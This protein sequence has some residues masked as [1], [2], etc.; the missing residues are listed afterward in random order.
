[1]SRTIVKFENVSPKK[2]MK[3]LFYKHNEVYIFR[4]KLKKFKGWSHWAE[5]IKSKDTVYM[6]KVKNLEYIKSNISWKE[7]IKNYEK[8]S[9]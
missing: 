6:G 7:L 1:V 3:E 2:I 5:N 8:G 4:I 9:S